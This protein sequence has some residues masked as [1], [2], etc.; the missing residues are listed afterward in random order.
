MSQQLRPVSFRADSK[1]T[2]I[3]RGACLECESLQPINLPSSLPVIRSSCFKS[4][5]QLAAVAFPTD[6]MLVRIEVA[7]FA[8]CISLQVLCVPASVEFV[9]EECFAG[10]YSLFVLTFQPES[11]LREL[12]DLPV[13]M[14]GIVNIPDSV[15]TLRRSGRSEYP[16]EYTLMFGRES[17]LADVR[18]SYLASFAFA[19]SPSETTMG[20]VSR[21]EGKGTG[22][23][24]FMQFSSRTV[25]ILRCSLEFPLAA[26]SVRRDDRRLAP[27]CRGMREV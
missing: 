26:R 22:I 27:S 23:R 8:F 21:S 5:D 1:L 19:R 18:P 13:R 4:C 24:G 3:E 9:G 11:H 15:E 14:K 7:A 2:A 17:R 16:A 6:S 25:K 12:L 10:C 20:L